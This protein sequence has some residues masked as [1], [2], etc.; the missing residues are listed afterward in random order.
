MQILKGPVV[1]KVPGS[2]MIRA[3]RL[4]A[5]TATPASASAVQQLAPML[6]Q[7][8]FAT[9]PDE[10]VVAGRASHTTLNGD[11]KGE[12]LRLAWYRPH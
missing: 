2:T 12:A 1:A 5:R 10:F 11:Q 8:A 7:R 6:A 4:E 9:A 3:S